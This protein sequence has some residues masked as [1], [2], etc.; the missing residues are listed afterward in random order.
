MAQAQ[1]KT[2]PKNPQRTETRGAPTK[3]VATDPADQSAFFDALT[4]GFERAGSAVGII[5]QHYQIAGHHICLRFAGSAMIPMIGPALSHLRVEKPSA[6]DLPVDFSIDLF[7]VKS[8][9]AS[10]PFLMARFIDL[11]RLRWWEHLESRGEIKGLSSDRLRAVFHLGP[12]ILSVLDTAHNRAVYWVEDVAKIPYYEKGYPLTVLLNWW[13]AKKGRYCVHAAAIGSEQGGVLLPGKGGSGKSTTS[14]ACMMEGLKNSGDDYTIVDPERLQ[15]HSLFNTIKLKSMDD[16]NRFPKLRK[17]VSNLAQVNDTEL[18][19]KAMIFMDQHFPGSL[20]NTMPLRAILVP[21]IVHQPNTVI[22]P[23]SPM[24]AF[25]ALAPSTVF[26]LPGNAHDAFASLGRLVRA[27]PCFDINL[28][29]DMKQT[30]RV[31][32]EFLKQH[33]TDQRIE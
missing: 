26:Q 29:S 12:D 7:D 8:T 14:L 5:E 24:K 20:I 1:M 22:T 2:V 11:L 3:V 23:T 32:R 4:E 21:R 27:L 17:C 19:E 30:P 6:G 31:I 16:V 9:E 13:L 25:K 15:A 10:L 33:Q 18:G 28:G